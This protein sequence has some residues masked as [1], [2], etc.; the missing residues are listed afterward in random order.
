VDVLDRKLQILEE[1]DHFK[2]IEDTRAAIDR[3]LPTIRSVQDP[4]L[5]D[6]YI[7]KVSERTGV[8]RDTLE[9]ELARAVGSPQTQRVS[10]RRD[11]RGSPT[12]FV[13]QMGPE[14]ELL[15]LMTKDRDWIE[16]VGEHL[17]PQDFVD[18]RYRAVFE[19]LLADHDLTHP[20]E[21]MAPEAASV[22]NE[23]L[24]DPTE[25]SRAHRVFEESLSKILSTFLQERLDAVDHLLQNTLDEQEESQLLAEKAR[26]SKERRELG[27]D[28]SP[29]ARRALRHDHL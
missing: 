1:H 29:A 24:A 19:A 17:G 8:R 18:V 13:P 23:L 28:W 5:R 27:R 9:G 11:R 3:L 7:A 20:P 6:I 14:R 2:S 26:L 25:L 15:L 10:R 12:T 22:L 4:A 16:R 21:T